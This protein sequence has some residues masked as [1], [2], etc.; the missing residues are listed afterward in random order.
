MHSLSH[1]CVVLPDASDNSAVTLHRRGEDTGRDPQELFSFAPPRD[2]WTQGKVTK[3]ISPNNTV[4]GSISSSR[5]AQ[6]TA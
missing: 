1:V 2:L 4:A 5:N 3:L 6:C